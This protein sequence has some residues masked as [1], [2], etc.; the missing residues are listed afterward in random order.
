[1]KEYHIW[2]QTQNKW[3][4]GSKFPI[5][6]VLQNIYQLIY[7]YKAAFRQWV[8]KSLSRFVCPPLPQELD[9]FPGR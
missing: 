9:N 8:K 6:D 3:F 7:V 1:M 2:H 5:S 4:L